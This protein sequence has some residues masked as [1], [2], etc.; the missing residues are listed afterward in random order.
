VI[1]IEAV[2]INCPPAACPSVNLP[3]PSF[4]VDP[5]CRS[6]AATAARSV[7]QVV[8]AHEPV[9]SAAPLTVNVAAEAEDAERANA[10]EPAA[11]H[12]DTGQASYV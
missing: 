4:T 10:T 9:P 6:A 1:V 7:V 3:L 2:S 11:N 8:P 5:G 12:L